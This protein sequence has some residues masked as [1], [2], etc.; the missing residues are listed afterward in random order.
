[1][2]TSRIARRYARA[3]FQVASGNISKAKKQY[4]SLRVL[5]TVCT[6]PDA[7]RVLSS[8]VMPPDLKR[9]LLEYGLSQTESDAD[10]RH[11]VDTVVDVGRAALIPEITRAFGELIDD[12]EGVVKAHV[13]SAVAITQAELDEIAIAV[14]SLLNKKAEVDLSVDPSLLGGFKVTVGQFLID[15]SLKTKLDGLSYRASVDSIR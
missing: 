2:P 13:V 14:G 11:L 15:L 1:M 6:N 3:L 4:E 9:S 8:P 7:Y 12:A 5:D 10:L